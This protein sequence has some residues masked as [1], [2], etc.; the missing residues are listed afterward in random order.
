[1]SVELR[2][3]FSPLMLSSNLTLVKQVSEILMQSGRL[4]SLWSAE[5]RNPYWAK[6][7]LGQP[8]EEYIDYKCFQNQDI[9]YK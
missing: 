8:C 2:A 7:D 4:A 3:H 5:V 6:R 1:M 9:G